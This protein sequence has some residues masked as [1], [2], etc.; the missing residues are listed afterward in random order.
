MMNNQTTTA[1]PKLSIFLYNDIVHK[2]IQAGCVKMYTSPAQTHTIA[3]FA[4]AI[5]VDEL[6]H[7]SY[8][9]TP[10]AQMI[11]KKTKSRQRKQK[12]IHAVCRD[13]KKLFL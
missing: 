12:G 9:D 4:I 11:W 8:G 1:H 6:Y 3:P 10:P 5:V 13:L 2:F 7:A